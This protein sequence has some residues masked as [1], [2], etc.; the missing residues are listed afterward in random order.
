[1]TPAPV[2]ESESPS[3]SDS[4][5]VETES[6]SPEIADVSRLAR[7][8]SHHHLVFWTAL[9]G[10]LILAGWMV[11]TRGHETAGH[12]LF[13]LGYL[14]GGWMAAKESFD[15]L[16]R[17]RLDVNVLM[18]L[19]AIGAAIIGRWA[20]GGTLIFLFSLSNTL[21]HYALERTK[22][23]VRSLMDLRPA[24]A[25][26][27][28][29][30][31]TQMVRVELLKVGDE[32]LIKPGEKIA[33]DGVIADGR[34]SIDRS[35]FTGESI[36][37]ECNESDEVLAGTLNLT[38]QI[39]VRV[40]KEASDTALAGIIHRVEQAQSGRV[41]TNSFVEWFGQRYTIGVLIG[42]TLLAVFPPLLFNSGWKFSFYRSLTLLVVA[43]P[44]ALIISTPAAVLSAIGRA[45]KRGI[46]FKGGAH[47]LSLGTV[48]AVAFD[49][50]GTL[51]Q[52]RACVAEV[53]VSNGASEDELLMLAA[54]V[55]SGSTHPL[56]HAIVAEA[57]KRRLAI[58][59]VDDATTIAGHGATGVVHLNGRRERV[60]VGNR[61][62]V[63]NH[64]VEFDGS[65]DSS[66][67]RLE[68]EG[69]T[70]VLVAT[71][72]VIGIIA[73]EDPP[74]PSAAKIAGQLHASGVESVG[75]LTGDNHRVAE[76]MAR[77]LGIDDVEAELLPEQKADAVSELMRRHKSV[78][79]VGDGV[80]D[81]PALA[82]ATIGVAMG[83]AKNDVVLETADVVLMG[84]DLS[85]LAYGIRLSKASRR[86]IIQNL[87]FALTVI[88]VLLTGAILGEIPL[89]I[90]V[91][92][93]EGSTLLVVMNSLRLLWFD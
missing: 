60:L 10:L 61:R 43:S 58:P 70:A 12:I 13:A 3:K 42:A 15:G 29:R 20:E 76:A 59:D 84:D 79:V 46:L 41:P 33:A 22:N 49:K 93:H 67:K 26:R 47:L 69:K 2:L 55:E 91:I 21:E 89:T 92:G 74:R 83:G 75:I 88:A 82:S 36:P 66:L 77:R 32:I 23:A 4:D 19:A 28:T 48:K 63:M 45:A 72:R 35:S 81:A 44:C 11:E 37:V 68:N 62:L 50:T 85:R 87:V 65:V 73:L 5:P 8:W 1:M 52:A 7:L 38:G 25:R 80:N 40:A 78:A 54:S 57:A 24:E 56:A 6:S 18:T 9:G 86:I 51:T 64:G 34:T 17:Y 14:S 31:G 30:G 16:R 53:A 39:T 71:D 90:G 27:L